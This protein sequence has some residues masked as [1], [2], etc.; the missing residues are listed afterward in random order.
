[1]GMT[2]IFLMI[3]T[4]FLTA[5]AC[6][7]VTKI[8]RA[9]GLLNGRKIRKFMR[10]RNP[11]R[12]GRARGAYGRTAYAFCIPK[13]SRMHSVFRRMHFATLTVTYQTEHNL[14][15][16]LELHITIELATHAW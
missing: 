11:V 1:M 12:D 10:F 6:A 15:T 4:A 9:R 14:G 8:R 3:D 5:T 13:V 7:W 16:A 2:V